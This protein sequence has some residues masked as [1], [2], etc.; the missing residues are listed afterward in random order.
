MSR[1]KDEELRRIA[2]TDGLHVSPFW[3]D[4]TAYGTR[5]WIWSVS[6]DGD[7]SARA[8]DITP[9]EEASS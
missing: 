5:T 2:E 3:E 8:Y 9:R 6:V 1:W 7:L 4:G